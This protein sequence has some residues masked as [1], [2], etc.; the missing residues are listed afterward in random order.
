R[1]AWSFRVDLE[2]VRE[3]GDPTREVPPVDEQARRILL[4]VDRL[5]RVGVSDRWREAVARDRQPVL[6]PHP[7]DRGL[8]WLEP[9]RVDLPQSGGGRKHRRARVVADRDPEHRV[10]AE[11]LE[12]DLDA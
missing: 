3:V 4:N 8:P 7:H 12:A 11:L 10:L 5:L 9:A 1:Y 2:A 6:E